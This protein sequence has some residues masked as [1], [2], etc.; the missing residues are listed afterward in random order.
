MHGRGQSIFIAITGEGAHEGRPYGGWKVERGR[1]RGTPLRGLGKIRK[2]E[3]RCGQGEGGMGPRM[4]EDNGGGGDDGGGMGHIPVSTGAGSPWEQREGK[5]FSLWNDGLYGDG[6]F[7]NRPYGRRSGC[8]GAIYFHSNHGRGRPRGAPLRGKV[9]RAC[10]RDAPRWK[11]R[12]KVER[13]C[14][15]D[16]P[17][18]EGVGKV[19]LR[20]TGFL[21]VLRTTCCTS[22]NDRSGWTQG[23][24]LHR[25]WRR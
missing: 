8:M 17:M 22:L 14:T 5:G 25:G 4:R 11:G 7:A 10:T 3:G 12:G 18:G 9:E 16:A 2:W 19:E 15:R 1:P 24:E 23:L 20:T 6:R 21:A 13:A